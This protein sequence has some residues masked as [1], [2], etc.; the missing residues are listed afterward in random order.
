MSESIHIDKHLCLYILQATTARLNDPLIS[1]QH[2]RSQEEHIIDACEYGLPR[3]TS[4]LKSLKHPLVPLGRHGTECSTWLAMELTHIDSQ[5]RTRSR[6][7][8]RKKSNETSTDFEQW[9]NTPRDPKL[10]D[11]EMQLQ[12]KRFY[13]AQVKSLD[14]SMVS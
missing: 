11:Q 2:D 6:Q 1:Q 9:S 5:V 3:T 14:L 4:Q 8:M 12:H 10:I 7:R 13:K